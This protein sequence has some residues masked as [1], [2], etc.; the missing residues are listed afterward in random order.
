VK[1]DVVY[2]VSVLHSDDGSLLL[3]DI[4]F[5]VVKKEV[6]VPCSRIQRLKKMIEAVMTSRGLWQGG[7]EVEI[8]TSWEKYGDL[9]LFN[10]DRYFKNPVWSE[11]GL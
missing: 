10:G 11:A 9:L 5:H 1:E 7:L 8:P 6:Y 2:D 4:P 3:N